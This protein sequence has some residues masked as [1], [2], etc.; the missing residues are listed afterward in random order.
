VLALL[1]AGR[2][3][4]DHNRFWARAPLVTAVVALLAGAALGAALIQ[5][6]LL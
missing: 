5:P 4:L 1:G 3:S 6:Q 2:L